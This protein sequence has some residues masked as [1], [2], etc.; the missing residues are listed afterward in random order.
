MCIVRAWNL[1]IMNINTIELIKCT[2]INCYPSIRRRSHQIQSNTKQTTTNSIYRLRAD[3]WMISTQVCCHFVTVARTRQPR[4]TWA[5]CRYLQTQRR[6]AKQYTRRHGTLALKVNIAVGYRVSSFS[7]ATHR[8]CVVFS[9]FFLFIAFVA[10]EI[11]DG[12]KR[13]YG[14]W[15]SHCWRRHRN[16]NKKW[17]GDKVWVI[18]IYRGDY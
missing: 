3:C 5:Q 1:W 14:K 16:N 15:F 17:N 7:I 12:W 2:Q 4:V 6:N 10:I 11:C 18:S 8:P 9:C 13:F